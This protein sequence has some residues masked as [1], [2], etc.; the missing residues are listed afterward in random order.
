MCMIYSQYLD[1]CIIRMY[2]LI[3]MNPHVIIPRFITTKLYDELFEKAYVISHI[4]HYITKR[5]K[6]L[7][8]F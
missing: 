4:F 8:F 6:I 3:I 7:S 1:L 5:A 2:E